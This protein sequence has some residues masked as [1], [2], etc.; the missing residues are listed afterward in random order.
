M[1]TL[2]VEDGPIVAHG[3][4]VLLFS[5]LFSL[6]SQAAADCWAGRFALWIAFIPLWVYIIEAFRARVPFMTDTMLAHTVTT[7]LTQKTSPCWNVC[8]EGRCSS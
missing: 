8:W 7:H 3:M 6:Y 2:R 1:G 4:R 5:L